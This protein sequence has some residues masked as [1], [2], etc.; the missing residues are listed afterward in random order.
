MSDTSY[1][2][3]DFDLVPLKPV[4]PRIHVMREDQTVEFPDD[5]HVAW[6]WY[7]AIPFMLIHQLFTGQLFR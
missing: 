4:P 3:D 1:P 7:L 6:Y 5:V 2:D